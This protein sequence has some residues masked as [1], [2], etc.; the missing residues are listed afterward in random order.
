MF[1]YNTQGELIETF[2]E[3]ILDS[4][5]RDESCYEL[6]CSDKGMFYTGTNNIYKGSNTAYC[7]DLKLLPYHM[8]G[9]GNDLMTVKKTPFECKKLC[10]I[11]PDCKA[12]TWKDDKECFLKTKASRYKY[13]PQYTT[14]V[15]FT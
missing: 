7:A 2:A 5:C 10:A 1:L 14:A 8:V 15:K 9:S 12:I 13:D 3:V 4:D 11:N 6:K